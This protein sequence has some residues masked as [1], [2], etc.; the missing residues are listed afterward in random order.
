MNK[1]IIVFLIGLVLI[2]G[3]NSNNIVD[4]K[5]QFCTDKDM[6]VDTTYILQD[7]WV[8]CCED[9]KPTSDGFYK[10]KCKN[11]EIEINKSI[12]ND[13]EKM[14]LGED[15]YGDFKGELSINEDFLTES[16][17]VIFYMDYID[18]RSK[19]LNLSTKNK[20][21][22]SFFSFD[23]IDSIEWNIENGTWRYNKEA[24][25]LVELDYNK[26]IDR[27][28]EICEDDYKPKLEQYN[29]PEN[30]M[31]LILDKYMMRY[32]CEDDE[33]YIELKTQ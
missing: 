12:L 31:I 29:P 14:Y 7:N 18:F 11:Y 24:Q 15:V 21:G 1:L 8:R 25:D 4:S 16:Q 6:T 9:Y 17:G 22:Y 28:I 5:E 30:C 13:S 10:M 23:E 26:G 27:G 19:T 33:Y 2:S 20:I 32:I 3:C